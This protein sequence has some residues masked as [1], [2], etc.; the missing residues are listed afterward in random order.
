MVKEM[1]DLCRHDGQEIWPEPVSEAALATR[2]DEVMTKREGTS[3]RRWRWAWLA[4]L[5]LAVVVSAVAITATWSSWQ[6][7]AGPGEGTVP[8]GLPLSEPLTPPGWASV[9]I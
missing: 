4:A 5:S 9:M 3:K 1:P 7:A 8:P 2:R 6:G